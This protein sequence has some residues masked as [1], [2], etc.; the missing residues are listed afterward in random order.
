MTWS[1]PA[2]AIGGSSLGLITDTVAML[3]SDNRSESV[4]VSL[5]QDRIQI[6]I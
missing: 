5:N 1:V 4:T 2:L 3:E 6:M